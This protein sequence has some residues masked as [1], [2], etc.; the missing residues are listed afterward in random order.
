MLKEDLIEI[1]KQPEFQKIIF[2]Y[3]YIIKDKKG[4][5]TWEKGPN[6][7]LR[8]G[9]LVQKN[10]ESFSGD[11]KPVNVDISDHVFGEPEAKLETL[12]TGESSG[13]GDL[14]PKSFLEILVFKDKDLNSKSQRNYLIWELVSGAMIDE[15]KEGFNFEID[16]LSTLSAYLSF[17]VGNGSTNNGIKEKSRS[18][19]MMFEVLKVV[20]TGYI[21]ENFKRLFSE[22]VGMLYTKNMEQITERLKFLLP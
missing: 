9:E 5:Y 22:S 16:G 20:K 12:S 21:A 7:K 6:R 13:R 4:V 14:D 15:Y 3:K 17:V 19:N 11:R 18:L 2:E 1:G 8:I 10:Q